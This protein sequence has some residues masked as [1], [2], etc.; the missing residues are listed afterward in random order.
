[1][2]PPTKKPKKRKSNHS[3][4]SLCEALIEPQFANPSTIS[5][6]DYISALPGDCIRSIFSFLNHDNLDIVARVSQR[7]N[8]FSNI[9]RSK[10]AKSSQYRV[11]KLAHD[12][13]RNQLTIWLRDPSEA[14]NVPLFEKE[15]VSES[16]QC[17]SQQNKGPN[18]S[19]RSVP[20]S[21]IVRLDSIM[22]RF[23]IEDA[24]FEG[25]KFSDSMVLHCLKWSQKPMKVRVKNG[26]F[27]EKFVKEKFLSMLL[28]IE[29]NH[30][31]VQESTIANK[32]DNKFIK[33]F[34]TVADPSIEVCDYADWKES[35]TESDL[36]NMEQDTLEACSAFTNLRL[37]HM[38]VN[39]DWIM[40]AIIKR[41]RRNITGVWILSL[42]RELTYPEVKAVISD[43][44]KHI[45]EVDFSGIRNITIMMKSEPRPK[46]HLSNLPGDCIR[47]VFKFL[48]QNSLDSLARVSQRMND[49][50]NLSRSD[51]AKSRKF[52]TLELHDDHIVLCG[53]WDNA[54]HVVVRN[55][56][57]LNTH[58]TSRPPSS[59]NHLSISLIDSIMSKFMIRYVHFITVKF[60]NPLLLH[61]LKWPHKPNKI[62][63]TKAI[64]EEQLAKE[65]LLSM[66]LNLGVNQVIFDRCA[67]ERQ[68]D[69]HF[70][71]EFSKVGNPS[72][73][74]SDFA[75]DW[76]P[77]Q[78]KNDIIAMDRHTLESCKRLRR[79]ENGAWQLSLT[80][81]L[82]S[83]DISI[84]IAYDLKGCAF[85]IGITDITE[86]L[87]FTPEHELLREGLPS[88]LR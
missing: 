86:A 49:F 48:N 54:N 1:M 68:I 58:Q 36:I 16:E 13:L 67:I 21:T 50:A 38:R 3:C 25:V 52:H 10:V 63:K 39:S 81:E 80:R 53:I 75:A 22:A 5:K 8:E 15:H 47:F 43:D 7:M 32:I 84:A 46:D 79:K 27:E 51:V 71:K 26:N 64:F 19:I 45:H 83:A 42:T 72:F 59:I 56:G 65:K 23:K 18:S 30:V 77:N 66:L 62:K 17:Q 87:P 4:C 82:T 44:L 69:N 31:I 35:G 33:E 29:V 40:T 57:R 60:N 9:S 34:C 24:H 61:C 70:I 2:E 28:A 78:N 55:S 76:R 20:H 88:S 14:F 41:F 85:G 11:V 12:K 73:E 37:F 74:V 6:Q